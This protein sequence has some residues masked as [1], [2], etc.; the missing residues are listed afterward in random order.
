VGEP[1]DGASATVGTGGGGGGGGGGDVQSTVTLTRRLSGKVRSSDPACLE[2]RKIVV[3]KVRRGRDRVV[4]R[5]VSAG[6]GA[7]RIRA[8][9]LKGRF[10]AIAK[11][12]VG[13]A[14]G[15]GTCL[16]ARS[17]KVKR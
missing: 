13:A 5:D 16:K 10:Y 1:T 6:S 3:K 17:K 2:G 9:N 4:G 7:Y 14:A 11:R 8:K 15:G 12:K